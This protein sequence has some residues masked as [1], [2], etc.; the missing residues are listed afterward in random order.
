MNSE[1]GHLQIF[2]CSIYIHVSKEKRMKLE[3]LG[4][5][6]TIVVYNESSKDYKI[7]NP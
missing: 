3:P 6:G 4:M 2:G 7:Y 5:K 1:V